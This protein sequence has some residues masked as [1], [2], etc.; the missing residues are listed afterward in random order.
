ML[1]GQGNLPPMVP[2]LFDDDHM[3]LRDRIKKAHEYQR[4][5]QSQSLIKS[6]FKT[7]TLKNTGSLTLSIEKLT[8]EQNGD[9]NPFSIVNGSTPWI[10]WPGQEKEIYIYYTPEY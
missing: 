7:F 8:V 1:Q 9:S 10:L 3:A 5:Y 4:Y 6:H 2:K